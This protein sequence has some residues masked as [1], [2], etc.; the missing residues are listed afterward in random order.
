MVGW[1]MPSCVSHRGSH[2]TPTQPRG[3]CSRR[4]TFSRCFLFVFCI[5]FLSPLPPGKSS[6]RVVCRVLSKFAKP[7][8][9]YRGLICSESLVGTP[10]SCLKGGG[11]GSH[12]ISSNG[13]GGSLSTPFGVL[14]GPLFHPL[15]PFAALR[16]YFFSTCI[17][18]FSAITHSFLRIAVLFFFYL[19]SFFFPLILLFLTFF[20]CYV[21]LDGKVHVP[22]CYL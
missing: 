10:I 5:I 21:L 12:S 8:L 17:L 16:Y 11:G 6:S 9:V 22:T 14:E 2:S 3:F 7:F 13:E 1:G 19:Y 18:F 15:T 20:L 4:R